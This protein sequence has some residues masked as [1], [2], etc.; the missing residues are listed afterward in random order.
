MSKQFECQRYVFKISSSRLRN[1]KWN[2]TL[3]LAEARKNEEVISLASSQVLRWIDELNGVTDAD[4]KARQLKQEIKRIRKESSSLHDTRKI[5]KL[6]AELDELQFKKDYMCLVIDR[7]SDYIR[8]CK[9]FT[10][11]GVKY[12]RLLGTPGG[13]KMSTI[14]FVSSTVVDELRRRINNDRDASRAFIP[15]KLEA[16]R[17]LTCSASTPVSE[18]RGVLVVND[19]ETTFED[20]VV[21]LSNSDDEFGEPIMSEP[22][23][24]TVT[25]TASDGCG[26]MH[27]SLAEK[28]SEDMRLSYTMSGCC[29]R[30]AWTKG[31]VYTFP[32][33]EFAENVAGK[34]IVKDAWGDEVDIRDVD[35]V[36]PVS[37]VKLW[38]SY[39]SCAEWLDVSRRNGYSFAVTK[40]CV[41]E[42]E[43]E[44]TLNYQ[45]EQIF[46][47]SDADVEE[48][49]TPTITE[50]KGVLG[51]D[52]AKT[53][54]YLNGVGMT[55][56]N[57]TDMAN[58]WQ[59]ALL[60]EPTLIEDPFIRS[61]VYSLI[62]KRI[63]KAKVGVLTVH[64]NYST[65][66]GDLYALCQSIFELPVT[67]LLK[68]G[69]VYNYFWAETDAEELLA[70]RAPMSCAENVR[71][72]RPARREDC[73]HWFRYM[74]ACTVVSGFSNEMSAENG[75]DFDGDL[76]MLTDNPVLL[77]NQKVLPTLMCAQSKGTKCIP[78]EENIIQSNIASFGNEVGAITNRVTSMYEVISKF[79]S[80]STE[81]NTLSY[82]IR[83][84]QLHQ[85]DCIDKAKGIISKPM[86][87]AWY[88][89]HALSDNMSQDTLDLYRDVIADRKPY[90]M[91]YVYPS[92]S[93]QYT[94]YVKTSNR[95]AVLQHGM[96]LDDLLN[97]PVYELTDDQLNFVRRY[98]MNMPVG[99][100]DCTMNRICRRVEAEFDGYLPTKK[101][102][103]RFDHTILKCGVGYTS[104][105]FNSIRH[106]KQ[107]F[108]RR[109]QEREIKKVKDARIANGDDKG[110]GLATLYDEFRS[111]C[112][113]VCSNQYELCDIL[114]DLCYEK[115]KNKRFAWVVCGDTIVENL[116]KRNGELSFVEQ[117]VDGTIVWHSKKFSVKTIKIGGEEE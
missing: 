100:G 18:P 67:G 39:S 85:Q 51:D 50:I 92:L 89:Y 1:S 87:K 84:G 63:D 117:D 36:L 7:N 57:V 14:V 29:I 11:N 48:L 58:T 66:S 43:S 91:R 23:M 15:A 49:V 111:A 27:P 116:L 83:C 45:F 72:V 46:D 76:L 97:K 20:L 93:K 55:E 99:M 114:I 35:L 95:N 42:L 10:I 22:H 40:V 113:Q 86:P 31:M 41:K 105:H 71:R 54:L 115:E 65:A 37:M 38:D 6:Y 53:V 33:D 106:L 44:R 69:E 59:K 12:E 107:E 30:M 103:I 21:N 24:E 110:L 8:A 61:T 88:D 78:T 104:S 96:S 28:W 26:M 77:R 62:R 108:D 17:A 56:K 98:R 5:K 34:Y 52:W 75:M 16:Y 101:K 109:V 4:A 94:S 9:G 79:D 73:R 82:R 102:E 32:F 2:L 25:L 112:N 81:Y 90:F 13:I 64:G 60:I 68:A 70:Y 47:L 74:T 80:N 19:V 3:P